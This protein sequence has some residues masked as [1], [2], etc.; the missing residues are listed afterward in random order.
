MKIIFDQQIFIFQKYGGISR[1]FYETANCIVE[2]SSNT[3][4]I[5]APFYVNEYFGK[6]S[7]VRLSGF[8]RPQRIRL[9]RIIN[10]INY[11]L[12][13]IF[14]KYRRNVDIFHETYYSAID[15]CPISAK[16]IITVY[17]MIHEKFP[18]Y[19]PAGNHDSILAEKAFAIRRADHVICISETT[20]NDLMQ[21]LSIPE[22]KISVV[23]LGSS[24]R[25]ECSDEQAGLPNFSKPY[26]LFVGSRIG[27]KNFDRLLQ[28]YASSRYLMEN[29]DIVCFGGESISE[30]EMNLMKSLDIP[31]EKIKLMHGDDAKLAR[32]YESATVFVYPS[33]YEGF[34]IPLLEAMSLGCPVACA[35]AGSIPEI[36]ADSAEYF[37]PYDPADICAAIGRI[38]T[39]SAH[40]SDLIRKGEIRSQNFSWDKCATAT[41]E[42]YQKVL[43]S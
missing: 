37:D 5:F 39:N 26:I 19:F 3:V 9:T 31:N 22:H 20:K 38:V 15:N 33:L 13:R 42:V 43:S 36:A 25:A 21:I 24:I 28:A 2:S 27:Y 7:T 16:R 40:R 35:N 17:D 32:L 11:L 4:D 34:G 12:P 6:K 41:L 18:E 8:K 23:Y 10:A 1:Y 30:T 14:V 29:F